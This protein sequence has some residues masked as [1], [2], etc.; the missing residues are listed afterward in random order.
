MGRVRVKPWAS[1]CSQSLGSEIL[2]VFGLV[3][4]CTC[5]VISGLG[6]EYFWVLC[7]GRLG[8]KEVCR[9]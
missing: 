6:L 1:Q 8:P 4:V 9:A 2:G 3:W 5:W 7:L